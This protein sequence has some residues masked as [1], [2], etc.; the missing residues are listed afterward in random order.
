MVC[1]EKECRFQQPWEHHVPCR[2]K[3]GYTDEGGLLSASDILPMDL[4]R[5]VRTDTKSPFQ[6]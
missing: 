4:T 6:G 1:F 2:R 5:R 3:K